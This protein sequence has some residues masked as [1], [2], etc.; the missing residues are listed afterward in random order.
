MIQYNDT[1]YI[2]QEI[3][4]NKKATNNEEE[5]EKK[6]VSLSPP[7]YSPRQSNERGRRNRCTLKNSPTVKGRDGEKSNLGEGWSS[8]GHYERKVKAKC[9]R[10]AREKGISWYWGTC[11]KTNE[12]RIE[13]V[14]KISIF[15][16]S[17][18]TCHFWYYFSPTIDRF[19]PLGISREIGLHKCARY[20]NTFVFRH[21]WSRQ[22]IVV[23]RT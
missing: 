16:S 10:W 20:N 23:S 8:I 12:V 22:Y 17:A 15:H 3:W 14:W 11:R 2:F 6:A 4:T 7:V 18:W 21:E 13:G 5:K 9:E 1:K 19:R